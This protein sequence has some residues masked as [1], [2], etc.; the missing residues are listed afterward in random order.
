VKFYCPSCQV[1]FTVP[2]DK[3]PEGKGLKVL[4]P[5]CRIPIERKDEHDAAGV[6]DE[7]EMER[8]VIVSQSYDEDDDDEE[9][10][11]LEVFEEGAKTALLCLSEPS[12]SEKMRQ[13]LRLLDY[14]VSVANS[15]KV[16]I[17]RLHKNRYDLVIVDEK[18]AGTKDSE[19]VIL[20]HVQLMPMPMRR[21]FFLC[22]LSENLPTL[23]QLRAFRL[24][25]DMILNV[26]DLDKAKVILARTMKDHKAFY[27][28]FTGELERK[29]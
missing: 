20:H 14:H 2:D 8:N 3:V 12:R 19:H 7:S 24:G 10:S 1:T 17:K 29:G 26:Q 28:V 15:A 23:D 13:M 6:P 9:S 21:Q 27:Q 25:V 22:L 18:V 11:T 16:A 4:C 5:K